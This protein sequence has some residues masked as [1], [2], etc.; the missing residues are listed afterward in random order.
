M[1]MRLI[2]HDYD[3]LLEAGV[4]DRH[5]KRRLK[6]AN[7]GLQLGLDLLHDVLLDLELSLLKLVFQVV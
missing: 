7:L 6:G 3:G 5:G 4:G 2:G 1:L